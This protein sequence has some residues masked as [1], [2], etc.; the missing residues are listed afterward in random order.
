MMLGKLERNKLYETIE[1]SS[2]DLFECK[3]TVSDHKV[4]ITHN[5]GSTFEF[6]P[7]ISRVVGEGYRV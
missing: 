6:E 2:L 4:V 3:L 7:V 1:A 5:S